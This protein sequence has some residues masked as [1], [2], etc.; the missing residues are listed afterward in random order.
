[1]FLNVCCIFLFHKPGSKFGF[2][3]KY[4]YQVNVFSFLNIFISEALTQI[5]AS[6]PNLSS[7]LKQSEV[8]LN[9]TSVI[10]PSFNDLQFNTLIANILMQIEDF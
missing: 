6:F 3:L 2:F 1:M 5:N 4:F 7:L 9:F 10:F 8:S